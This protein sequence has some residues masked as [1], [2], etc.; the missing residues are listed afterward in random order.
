MAQNDQKL[1]RSEQREAARAMAKEMREAQKKSD[2]R[3][4]LSIVAGVVALILG[5]GAL[6][7]WS[8]IANKPAPSLTPTNLIYDN[9]I[10]MG[11]GVKAFTP[12]FKPNTQDVPVIKI[13]LDYQCPICQAFDVPNSSLIESKV[14]A[15]EWIV[16]YHP[17]SFLDGRASP[18]TYS[19]R[20]ANSAIC[21]SEYDPDKFLTYTNLLYAHQPAENTAGPENDALVKFTEQVQVKN[22]DKIASCINDKSFGA[23]IKSTTDTA[24]N[25]KVPGTDLNVDGTPFIVV[26]GQ[27]YTWNTAA[28]LGSPARFEQ[29]VAS[30]WASTN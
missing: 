28:D 25:E 6:I 8:V 5:V 15:G 18:N 7:G 22:A 26:K 10:R 14:N 9:G 3:R 29:W 20:A 17:I 16:E 21:V 19:S 4:K 23:W 24:L 12:T 11:T 13:Y 1:T 30:A 2:Q 27:K